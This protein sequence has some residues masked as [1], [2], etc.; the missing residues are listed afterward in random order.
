MPIIEH[1]EFV[2]ASVERCFDL[3]RDVD[4]HTR[5][6]EGTKEK[7][8]GGITTGLLLAGDVVTWEAVHFGIRQRLTAKVTVMD[9]PY[10]FEDIMV[11]GAFHSFHHIHEFIEMDNGTLMIDR[12]QYT[13]PYGLIGVIADKLFLE[14]YMRN[15]IM[16][17]A[18]ALRHIAENE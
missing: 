4:V 16:S 13:S 5:T 1:Q 15:F 3:A 14:S 7:A 6:T 10:K 12:F 8:V 9:R 18:R 17:R 11:K 2:Q